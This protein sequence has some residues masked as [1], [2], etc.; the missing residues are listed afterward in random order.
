MNAIYSFKAKKGDDKD[1]D[2]YVGNG[3]S[4][5][6]ILL[7]VSCIMVLLVSL[8]AYT[9]KAKIIPVPE[10]KKELKPEAGAK[11]AGRKSSPKSADEY[12]LISANCALAEEHLKYD[13]PVQAKEAAM[14]VLAAGIDEGDQLWGRAVAVLNK[15]NS[16]VIS[17][18]LPDPEKKSYVVQ[19]GDSLAKIASDSNMTLDLLVKCNGL[20]PASP[21]IRSGK[22]LKLFKG[23]WKLEVSKKRFKLYLYNGDNLFKVYNIGIGTQE[24]TPAGTFEIDS[25]RKEPVWTKDGKQ[26]PYG[27]KENI[28]GT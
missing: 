19:K 17:T 8:F 28:L 7:I 3:P 20:N 14:K 16:L 5:W 18:D 6:V 21:V 26:I 15:V 22:T 4:F 23:N 25:K 10:T 27:S 2:A 24:K 1:S 9:Q 13:R 11:W 12:K